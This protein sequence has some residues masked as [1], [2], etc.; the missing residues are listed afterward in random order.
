MTYSH[1][2]A[3]LCLLGALAMSLAA[4]A[5]AP[6]TNEAPAD[7]PAQGQ[8]DSDPATDAGGEVDRSLAEDSRLVRAITLDDLAALAVV[9]GDQIIERRVTEDGTPVVAAQDDATG[10]NYGLFG[11][12]CNESEDGL[13]CSGINMMANWSRTEANGAPETLLE[14]NTNTAA[15]SIVASEDS[16]GVSRYVILDGGQ[17]MEN[18]KWN[19]RVFLNVSNSLSQNF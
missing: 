16:I 1:G 18:L 10:L 7:L 13:R 2:A 5:Q 6:A 17:T 9:E 11:T 19:L 15:V 4:H 3:A 14:L 12:A 8:A